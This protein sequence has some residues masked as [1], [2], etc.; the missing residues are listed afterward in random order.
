MVK[1]S[2]DGYFFVSGNRFV[3]IFYAHRM[4]VQIS[5][6]KPVACS[7]KFCKTVRCPSSETLLGYRR[8]RVTIVE[9]LLVE[10]H[11]RE[12]DFCSAELELLKRHRYEIQDDPI[13]EVPSRVRRLASALLG[14]TK[15]LTQVTNF[16]AYGGQLS[17]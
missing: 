12:C 4:G 14:Q 1:E 16:I 17:H 11:L 8:N 5:K 15:S 9:R 10:S 2:F 7:Q 3:L 13:A 6:M